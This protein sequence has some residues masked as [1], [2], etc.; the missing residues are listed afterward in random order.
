MAALEE[1][2]PD[3]RQP[4][5][6]RDLDVVETDHRKVAGNVEPESPRAFQDAKRLDVRRSEDRDLLALLGFYK[7][8]RAFVRGEVLGFQLSSD[9]VRKQ[10]AGMRPSE[11]RLD[12]LERGLYGPGR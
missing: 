8:D 4:C 7:C 9:A 5:V 10:L 6:R 2:L 1:R 12:G 3:R 11:H